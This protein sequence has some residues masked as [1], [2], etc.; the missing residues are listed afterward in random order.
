MLAVERRRALRIVHG[1][2]MPR[3]ESLGYVVLLVMAML[4]SLSPA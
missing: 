2:M 3:L 1:R 4:G